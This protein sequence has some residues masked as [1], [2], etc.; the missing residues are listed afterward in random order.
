MQDEQNHQSGHYRRIGHIKYR[1]WADVH[2]IGDVSLKQ[3][4][5]QIA[6]C[7][8]H[9][10]SQTKA[11]QIRGGAK[12]AVEERQDGDAEKG[13][14]YQRRVLVGEKAEGTARVLGVSYPEE[15]VPGEGLPVT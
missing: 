15:P 5:Q 4:V 7:A 8:T 13:H 12:I 14:K 3:A 9:L 11:Q 2:K 6:C 10:K 1:P